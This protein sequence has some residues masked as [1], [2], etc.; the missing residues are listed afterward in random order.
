M[1]YGMINCNFEKGIF[2]KLKLRTKISNLAFF[3]STYLD[4]LRRGTMLNVL[5][6]MFY[7][8]VAVGFNT[9]RYDAER[10][11]R[12][13]R[14]LNPPHDKKQPRPLCADRSCYRFT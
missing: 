2:Y 3:E 8:V 5:H 4:A 13:N 1:P 14:V 9:L 6:C 12:S 7:K 11:L 10:T